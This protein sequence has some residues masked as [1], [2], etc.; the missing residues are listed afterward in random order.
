MLGYA[1][2]FRDLYKI[3]NNN[4]LFTGDLAYKDKEGFYYLTGRKSRFIKI[5]GLRYSLDE[6][7]KEINKQ[8]N[9]CAILGTDD[10]LNIFISNNYNKDRL[11]NLLFTNFKIRKSIVKLTNVSKI[12]RNKNGKILYSEL[13]RK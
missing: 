10:Y 11:L 8:G 6:I 12:Q 9:N 4:L 3:R 2:N 13:K 5:F 7:E 1:R